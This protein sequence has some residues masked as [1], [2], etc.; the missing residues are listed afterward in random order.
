M[1]P[2]PLRLV[3]AILALVAGAL[4]LASGRW[5]G[6]AFL[7]VAGLLVW[8]HFRQGPVRRA[9]RA[10]DRGQSAKAAELIA[11]VKSPA[12]LD[13]R[14]RAHYHY[15]VGMLA[16][17]RGDIA[18]AERHLDQSLSGPLATPHDRAV[19][20]CYLADLAAG[21]GDYT[22]ARRQLDRARQLTHG[23]DVDST[24]AQIESII[25]DGKGDD[26]R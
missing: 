1:L 5:S 3:L 16:G 23:S 25:A 21:C 17:E 13:D 22:T 10:L 9:Y 11:K 6:A 7:V 26:D 20:A 14:E 19:V 12:R 18:S 8:G 4:V 24:I 15:V 2:T